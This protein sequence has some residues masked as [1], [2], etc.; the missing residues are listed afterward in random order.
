VAAVRR[1]R[2]HLR[3]RGTLQPQTHRRGRKGKFTAERQRRLRDLVTQQ[4][5]AT[6]EELIEAMEVRVASSTMHRWVT[7]LGLTRLKKVAEG[8]R[9][10]T[11]RRG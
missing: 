6:L 8:E 1:V 9:A 3:E 2:Q 7:R 4:P 11:P 10:A 5:D